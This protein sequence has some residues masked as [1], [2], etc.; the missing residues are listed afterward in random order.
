ML[1]PEHLNTI[2][3]ANRL[4]YILFKQ[5]KYKEAEAMQRRAS[6]GGEKVLG[7][8]HPETVFSLCE[9]TIS[10]PIRVTPL[11]VMGGHH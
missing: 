10:T 4:G 8:G 1:G 7:P 6:E 3:S 5:G 11:R 2:S 9:L